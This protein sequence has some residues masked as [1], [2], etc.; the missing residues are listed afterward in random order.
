MNLT[1]REYKD[2]DRALLLNLT[3]K[4]EE[5]SKS[6]DPIHRVQNLPGF[7]EISLKETL[8]NVEKY[9]G[10]IWIAEDEGKVIGYVIGVIWKQSEKNKLEIGPHKLGEVLKI[11]LDEEYRR[12]G[13]GK[14]MLQMMEKYFKEKGCNS[15]WIS[16][17]APNENAHNMYKKFG[18]VDREI[19][20]LKQI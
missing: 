11:Y 13:I 3:N 5:F 15:M 18:F 12:K 9:Q 17:F 2:K 4:L 16:V 19:G 1:F 10:K 6:L 8:G 7:T 20:M 14:T